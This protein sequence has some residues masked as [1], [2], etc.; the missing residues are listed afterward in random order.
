MSDQTVAF[1]VVFTFDLGE[2]EAALLK[3]YRKKGV[4]RIDALRAYLRDQ[5]DAAYNEGGYL[6]GHFS[7]PVRVQPKGNPFLPR[8]K[9]WKPP[10]HCPTCAAERGV[11]IPAHCS[12]VEAQS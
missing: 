4:S 9:D 3:P 1:S 6:D 11:S 12:H 5:L 7:G 8:G 2:D 10:V